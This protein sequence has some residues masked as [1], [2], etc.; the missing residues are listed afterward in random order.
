MFTIDIPDDFLRELLNTNA[1]DVCQEA[2]D[3]SAPLLVESMKQTINRNIMH[4]DRST[5]EL[6]ESIKADKA[7]KKKGAWSVNVGPKGNSRI[8]YYRPG[9]VRTRTST[10][11]N[12]LKLI[13]M[14][15][16]NS[17]QDARPVLDSIC[18]ECNDDV[19]QKLQDAYNR[20]VGE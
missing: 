13:M 2:L 11:T 5:G 9:E 14:E 8:Y 12:A 10:T 7:S 17:K 20:R 15:Y 1:D 18:R 16:G 19:L 3:E 6:V 4:H